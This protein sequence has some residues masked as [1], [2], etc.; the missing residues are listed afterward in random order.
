MSN[1]GEDAAYWPVFFHKLNVDNSC[2]KTRK[3]RYY[4]FQVLPNFV[5]FLYFAP[6]IL[7]RILDLKK[8]IYTFLCCLVLQ[9]FVDPVN[10]IRLRI[11]VR[12]K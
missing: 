1:V 3:I 12:L 11:N 9:S 10:Q 7:S 6:N 5:V 8:L 2:Q 4:V